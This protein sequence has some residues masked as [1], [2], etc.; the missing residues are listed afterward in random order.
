MESPQDLNNDFSNDNSDHIIPS[1]LDSDPAL[2]KVFI[3]GD[4]KQMLQ[5]L[6]EGRLLSLSVNME[7]FNIYIGTNHYDMQVSAKIPGD[8][9]CA[10]YVG[11]DK[12]TN[13]FI[14]KDFTDW[15]S[16]G[17]SHAVGVKL[18]LAQAIKRD[19]GKLILDK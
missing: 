11:F 3:H 14:I 6:K 16:G 10:A 7:N 19:I 5:Y 18:A 2:Y 17:E 15:R 12:S 4:K 8:N 9:F 1:D 13:K